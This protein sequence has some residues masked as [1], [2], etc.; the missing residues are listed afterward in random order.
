MGAQADAVA[1]L[2]KVVIA[3]RGG[4]AGGTGV[5]RLAVVDLDAAVQG[6]LVFDVELISDTL[7]TL[8]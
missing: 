1:L 3:Q 7:A 5:G 2:P 6:Q 8:M 4:H